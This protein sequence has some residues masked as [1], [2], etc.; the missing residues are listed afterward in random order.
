MKT[1]PDYLRPGL[2]IVSI[3]INPS[4]PSVERGFYFANPRNRFWR[5]LNASRL[6]DIPLDPGMASQQQ[7]MNEFGIGFT[8]LVKRPSANAKELKAAD[9][10]E[11]APVLRGKLLEY[12]PRIAW[13]Q[14]K[15]AYA[16]YLRYAE[17]LKP[18]IGWGHQPRDIS[19]MLC[20]V[21][22]NPSPANAAYSLDALIAWYDRLAAI[23]DQLRDVS[24]A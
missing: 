12:Q 1:L 16:H 22:P 24:R 3:G 21:T 14:G 23:R 4:L 20:F 5:A 8:D 7:M 13:F 10:R 9:Y 2:D 6:V 18:D 11:W 19:G 15:L 17:N